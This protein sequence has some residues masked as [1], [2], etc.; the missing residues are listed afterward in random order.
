MPLPKRSLC[1][2]KRSRKQMPETDVDQHEVLYIV[3]KTSL[4]K[5]RMGRQTKTEKMI[6]VCTRALQSTAYNVWNACRFDNVSFF[7]IHYDI[8]RWKFVTFFEILFK[9]IHFQKLTKIVSV[10][11][12]PRRRE[13]PWVRLS[14]SIFAKK[15]FQQ[16]TRRWRPICN[17]IDGSPLPKADLQKGLPNVKS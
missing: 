17:G 11:G 7:T 13:N 15:R 1:I 16:K 12:L 3:F 5:M 2:C 10:N 8:R 14:S 6:K 9:I 4:Q